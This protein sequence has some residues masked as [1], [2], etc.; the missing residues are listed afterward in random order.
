VMRGVPWY[1][2]GEETFSSMLGRL[3]RAVWARRLSRERGTPG[4][5]QA[6]LEKLLHELAAVR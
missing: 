5:A 2:R 4:E 6:T 1:A 3:R